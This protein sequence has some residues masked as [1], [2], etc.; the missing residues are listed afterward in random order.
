[1]HAA[2][3]ALDGVPCNMCYLLAM[4]RK[5]RLGKQNNLTSIDILS[6]CKLATKP[7]HCHLHI[8]LVCWFQRHRK[9]QR[10]LTAS[11]NNCTIMVTSH[12]VLTWHVTSHADKLCSSC[13][14]TIPVVA[15]NSTT[16][17]MGWATGCCQAAAEKTDLPRALKLAA[18][19][20]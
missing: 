14:A 13:K 5:A 19:L 2:C 12:A 20:V 6:A 8:L 15:P 17:I 1:M 11:K 10:L 18:A 3:A 9:T 4:F 7:S 16:P